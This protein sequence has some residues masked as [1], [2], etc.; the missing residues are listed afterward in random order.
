M[1]LSNSKDI[2]KENRLFKSKYPWGLLRQKTLIKRNIRLLRWRIFDME[3]HATELKGQNRQ[4]ELGWH[5][6]WFIE[7]MTVFFHSECLHGLSK[8]ECMFEEL[9]HCHQSKKQINKNLPTHPKQCNIATGDFLP[10]SYHL[11][12]IHGDSDSPTL[13]LQQYTLLSSAINIHLILYLF[14]SCP[15]PTLDWELL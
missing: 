5:Y 14:V 4:M 15:F 1:Y 10:F 13:M 9:I 2:H 8:K 7:R 6:W 3:H 11:M 12:K